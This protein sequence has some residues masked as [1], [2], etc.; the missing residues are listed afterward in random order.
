MKPMRAVTILSC[1][2]VVGLLTLAVKSAL[3]ELTQQQAIDRAQEYIRKAGLPPANPI[4]P[5]WSSPA[6]IR[7]SISDFTF[8]IRMWEIQLYGDY[9]VKLDAQT[10]DLLTFDHSRRTYE[11][12]HR[13][14]RTGIRKIRT[15]DEAKK[16]VDSV[17]KAFGLPARAILTKLTMRDSKGMISA[18]YTEKPFGYPQLASGN[19]MS[20]VIDPQDAMP[21]FVGSFWRTRFAPPNRRITAEHALKVAQREYDRIHQTGSGF[22]LGTYSPM[23]PPKLGYVT[24]NS[25]LNPTGANRISP[26][27][28]SPLAR[29]A[30]VV[31]FGQESVWIDAES[32]SPLGAMIFK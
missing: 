6:S 27:R 16:R 4:P 2:V 20:V 10:G 32:A 18:R 3:S 9:A 30:W 5:G 26:N 23:N 7:A 8:G 15:E 19:G 24:P 11:L 31:H 13:L 17:A 14:N 21:K 12:V 22:H 29:L 25:G 1:L 28:S